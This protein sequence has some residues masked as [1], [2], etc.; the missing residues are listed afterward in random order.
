MNKIEICEKY[1]LDPSDILFLPSQFDE[2]IAG[3]DY[4]NECIVYY[5]DKVIKCLMDIDKMD[6][7]EANE[8]F[9]YN[10]QGSLGKGFPT[11]IGLI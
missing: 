9:S 1:E 4:N 11:Y 10:I 5:S 7:E 8:Y 2:C 6:F 3:V